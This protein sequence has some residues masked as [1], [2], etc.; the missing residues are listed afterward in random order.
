MLY[1]FDTVELGRCALERR[2]A[3]KHG[4]GLRKV[5]CVFA[6]ERPALPQRIYTYVN[7]AIGGV[8]PVEPSDDTLCRIAIAQ[9]LAGGD[10]PVTGSEI[11]DLRIPPYMGHVSRSNGARLRAASAGKAGGSLSA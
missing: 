1:F 8:N 11:L 10:G 9:F 6:Q 2:T 5:F 4:F 3:G 7:N